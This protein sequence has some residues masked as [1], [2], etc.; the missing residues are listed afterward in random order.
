TSNS[1]IDLGKLLSSDYS[2]SQAVDVDADGNVCGAATY[3]PTGQSHAMLWT[4]F[5]PK[6]LISTA[7]QN[8]VLSW[9]TNAVGFKLQSA[10]NLNPPINWSNL[11]NA[12]GRV[13]TQ[14]MVTNNIS[15]TFKL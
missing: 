2:T 11:T 4:L 7:G 1:V 5:V 12:A 13:G 14:F 6:L 9:P 3:I 15:N 8:V 10:L